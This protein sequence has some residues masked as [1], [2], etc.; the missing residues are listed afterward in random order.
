MSYGQHRYSDCEIEEYKIRRALR[1]ADDEQRAD[2]I[3][4]PRPIHQGEHHAEETQGA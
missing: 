3:P 2:A 4:A 1:E